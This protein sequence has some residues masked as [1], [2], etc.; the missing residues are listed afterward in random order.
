M[1]IAGLA[2]ICASAC[3]LTVLAGG[4][5]G[6]ANRGG[7][8][9]G[10]GGT[11]GGSS[12]GVTGGSSSSSGGVTGGSSSGSSSGGVTGGS[13]SSS[14]GVTGGS[15][16][17]GGVT[18]GSSSGSTTT[19]GS[20][21]SSASDAGAADATMAQPG[22]PP[23]VDGGPSYSGPTVTAKVTVDSATTMGGLPPGFVG[24][25]YEKSHLTD[26]FFAA[27]D[28]PL[29]A[30]YRL[31]GPCVVRIGGN[32]VDKTTW[33]ASAV[34]VA[35]GSISSQVGTADVDGLSDFLAATG[36][37]VIYGLNFNTSTPAAA[38]AEAEY[39]ATKLGASLEAFE[40]GN[41]I[42]LVGAWTS[43]RPRWESFAAAIRAAV[44]TAPL[45][46]PAAFGT[47][48]SSST[49][50]AD[51]FAQDEAKEIVL[52]TQHYYIAGAGS[53][54]TIA[55][56][57][58]E[59]PAVVTESKSL[60]AAASANHVALGFRW[61]E[62]NSYAHHGAPGVSDALAS[63]FWGI[64]FMLSS[65][66]YGSAGVNFH[67]GSTGM[68]GTVPFTYA[69]IQEVNGR[70][71]SA[72]PLYYG[73]LLVARTA[74]GRMLST[75][76]DAGALDMSAYAVASS[77]GAMNVVLLN[78]DAGQGARVSVNLGV[79]VRSASAVYLSGP[80]LSATD[81]E[82]FAGAA[83][84]PLGAWNPD[85]PFALTPQGTTFEVLVPPASAVLVQAQ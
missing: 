19:S 42:N 65:A 67:G 63:A 64:D 43:V 74:T 17:S 47:S 27:N 26:G 59:R 84:T 35:A 6:V 60:T 30:L 46:G 11:S 2:A 41:E 69:P 53:G 73:M 66:E 80:S 21:S 51:S 62:A 85:P 55:D 4:C 72:A 31:L 81:R 9:E 79:S 39:V 10:E 15:S 24:F 40:I 77:G 25:S 56:M 18:G 82:T 52:L 33:Q 83:V 54:S 50:Y 49:A 28:A 14:G 32:D 58:T 5:S 37:K 78:K 48:S 71:A 61:G 20:S 8:T 70:V 45:A 29:I 57:L 22:W 36:W 23:A 7:E 68:D 75:V 3:F 16:S 13:S 76:V 44:P 38:A 1:R 34:P 12:G